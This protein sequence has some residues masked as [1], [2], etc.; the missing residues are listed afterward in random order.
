MA[1]HSCVI[2]VTPLLLEIHNGTGWCFVKQYPWFLP[3]RRVEI[4]VTSDLT[5]TFVLVQDISRVPVA[6]KMV[7]L[8]IAV[9]IVALTQW[10]DR[11]LWHM[12]SL[13]CEIV[14]WL[15]TDLLS[16]TYKL[17]CK[18]DSQIM[19]SILEINGFVHTNSGI[20]EL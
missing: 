6:I 12:W 5:V 19:Q 17:S 18:Q 15:T 9:A 1:S 14:E 13:A 11:E 20:N 4:R 7:E 8:L 2:F 3:F 16:H 10:N